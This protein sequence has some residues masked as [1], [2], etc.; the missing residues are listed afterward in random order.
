MRPG[1]LV[2]GHGEMRLRA[3]VAE[4]PGDAP[5]W[6]EQV[7]VAGAQLCI[8]HDLEMHPTYFQGGG[9]DKMATTTWK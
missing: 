6:A 2:G 9:L 4:F 1:I 7:Q 8:P 3:G 5:P